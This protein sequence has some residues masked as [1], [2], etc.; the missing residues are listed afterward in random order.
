MHCTHVVVWWNSFT[1]CT[2]I[3]GTIEAQVK[4]TQVYVHVSFSLCSWA[5]WSPDSK[6]SAHSLRGQ[7]Q[8]DLWYGDYQCCAAQSCIS[9]L[10]INS[11]VK[12]QGN[13]ILCLSPD[14]SSLAWGVSSEISVVHHWLFPYIYKYYLNLAHAPWLGLYLHVRMITEES[15]NNDITS[16][17]SCTVL[18]PLTVVLLSL[19]NH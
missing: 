15:T 5:A 10:F 17:A 6:A 9:A 13:Y 4:T 14:T 18:A 1:H 3:G 7:D 19:K 11:R 8:Q 2:W 12:T 16:G